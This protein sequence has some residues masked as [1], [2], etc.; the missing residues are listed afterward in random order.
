MIQLHIKLP[1]YLIKYLRK[2]YGEPYAPVCNDEIGLFIMSILEKKTSPSAYKYIFSRKTDKTYTISLPLYFHEKKGCLILPEKEALIQKFIDNH[3]RRE[4]YRFAILNFHYH[5]I[6]FKDS[7]E[8][9]L[10]VFDISEDDLT[11]ESIRKDFNRK[12]KEFTEKLII[13]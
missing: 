8:T 10:D 4:M 3:F 2:L 5:N 12:K 7:L 9:F 13:N 1:T 11:Y 6:K